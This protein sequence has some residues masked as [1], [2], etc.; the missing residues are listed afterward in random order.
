MRQES[1]GKNERSSF[2][3]PPRRLSA[4]AVSS[5]KFVLRLRPRRL[6]ACGPEAASTANPL[7]AIR[8]TYEEFIRAE[9]G[10]VWR[11]AHLRPSFRAPSFVG[12]EK[13]ICASSVVD[14]CSA[15]LAF[16]PPPLSLSLSLSPCR[17]LSSA[18]IDVNLNA[19]AH[20]RVASS[21]RAAKVVNSLRRSTNVLPANI[22]L[23]NPPPR[24]RPLCQMDHNLP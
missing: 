18:S 21:S 7:A 12:F 19:L 16:P 11:R 23:A 6:S 15:V 9:A 17:A 20:R 1:A 3:P 4:P 5:T 10:R 24:F 2:S 22:P 14:F 8:D 13:P